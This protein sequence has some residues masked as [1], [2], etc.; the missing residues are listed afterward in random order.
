M[1]VSC[2]ECNRPNVSDMGACPG[3]G[4]N[5]IAVRAIAEKE[6]LQQKKEWEL[7]MK[8]AERESKEEQQRICKHNWRGTD[9]GPLARTTIYRCSLCGL[10]SQ[11][12]R[13]AES[14]HPPPS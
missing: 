7:K 9:G 11:D 12:R 5:F 3:C 8:K 10:S 6:Y 4:Y 2:P 13:A 14:W 1:L